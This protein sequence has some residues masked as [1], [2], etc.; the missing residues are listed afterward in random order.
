MI[1]LV[2]S[3]LTSRILYLLLSIRGITLTMLLLGF[4]VFGLGGRSFRGCIKSDRMKHLSIFDTCYVSFYLEMGSDYVI[5]K[6][7]GRLADFFAFL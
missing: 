3:A 2:Y 5:S 7:E 4:G 6:S 1:R